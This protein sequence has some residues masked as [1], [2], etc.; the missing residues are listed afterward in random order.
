MPEEQ[1]AV[2][3]EAQKAQWALMFGVSIE[4]IKSLVQAFGPDEQG[5]EDV[6]RLSGSYRGRGNAGTVQSVE[7]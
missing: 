3:N 6:L 1:S 7:R 5:L 4:R 2:A